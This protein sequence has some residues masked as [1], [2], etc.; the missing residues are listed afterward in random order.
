MRNYSICSSGYV[1]DFSNRTFQEFILESTGL[2]IYNEKY[3]YGSGSKANLLRGF[4]QVETNY[5]VQRLNLAL[6]EYWKT[7]NLLNNYNATQNDIE[8]YNECKKVSGSLN[9]ELVIGNIETIQVETGDRNF[10]RLA[11]S[12]RESIEK[13]EPEIA[14]DRL[15]TFTV[16]YIRTL[17]DKHKIKYDKNKALHSSFGEF[18]KYLKSS[19]IIESEMTER[20]LKSSISILEAFNSVRN[21]HSLAHD[22]PILNSNESMLIFKNVASI[23]QFLE[24]VE[25]LHESTKIDVEINNFN[26]DLPF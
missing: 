13:N 14:L 4:W 17:C 24:Q 9:T 26:D 1:L 3:T 5:N 10:S 7:Y 12:I 16:K 23:I 25:N 6:L 18:I 2:D 21:E 20:I 15:H 22:N 11:N 8:L 19:K